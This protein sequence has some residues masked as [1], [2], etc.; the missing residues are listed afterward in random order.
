MAVYS[1]MHPVIAEVASISHVLSEDTFYS[2]ELEDPWIQEVV[3]VH[4]CMY[5]LNLPE[6]PRIRTPQSRLQS[7]AE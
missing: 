6:S 1:K 7:M 4:P 5:I 2:L 3:K